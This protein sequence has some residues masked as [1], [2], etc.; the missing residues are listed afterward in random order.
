MGVLPLSSLFDS[1][2][3]AKAVN[4]SNFQGDLIK[5][6]KP[7]IS[8]TELSDFKS[9][10]SAPS[11]S[12]LLLPAFIGAELTKLGVNY[13]KNKYDEKF[14]ELGLGKY[15]PVAPTPTP[16]PTPIPFSTPSDVVKPF[17][18][19]SV[20]PADTLISVL[21]NS[22]NSSDNIVNAIVYSNQLISDKIQ[23]LIDLVS[24][25]SDIDIAYKDATLVN[26]LSK[27]SS[28][29]DEA[30]KALEDEKL[31]SDAYRDSALSNSIDGVKAI[32]ALAPKLTELILHTQRTPT[33]SALT[34]KK[35]E[36]ITYETTPM[37]HDNLGD[38]VP[39]MTPQEMRA[40]KD[41]AVAQKNSDE[42]TFELDDDDYEDMFGLP[43]IT[44]IFSR[45]TATD[46]L[47]K[48]LLGDVT[49]A[50]P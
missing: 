17:E 40:K 2:N 31:A 16:N 47:E 34:T 29:T 32:E 11:V 7:Q 4:T 26:E 41:Y 6:V 37:S 12:R 20:T 3:T 44:D 25:N 27:N 35:L 9:S 1:V 13:A 38:V 46:R 14:K 23:T 21:K 45:W 5:T 28:Q 15:A 19:S 50:H 24:T 36:H 22:V 8:S 49:N 10:S 39:E 43:D 42:N 30:K 48:S 33:E 18:S